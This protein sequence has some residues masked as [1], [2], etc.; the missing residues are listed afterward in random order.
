MRGRVKVVRRDS[1]FDLER[2]SNIGV[3][4][5]GWRGDTSRDSD[6]DSVVML[7]LLLN[8]IAPK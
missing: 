2:G 5:L 7:L 6:A 1:G 4:R 3:S 8:S